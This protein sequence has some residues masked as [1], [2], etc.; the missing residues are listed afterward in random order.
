MTKVLK[1][2]RILTTALSVHYKHKTFKLSEFSFC[3]PKLNL[4]G[5]AF[6]D[7][8]MDYSGHAARH[9]FWWRQGMFVGSVSLCG[10]STIAEGAGN[11]SAD[12]AS[13][14]KV[15]NAGAG[16]SRLNPVAKRKAEEEQRRLGRLGRPLAGK[17]K[18]LGSLQSILRKARATLSKT[19]RAPRTLSPMMS[20]GINPRKSRYVAHVLQLPHA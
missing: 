6:R 7:D 8:T 19:L 3:D 10:D 16:P 14:R 4:F 11:E 5:S 17:Q 15:A 12:M 1:M 20:P 18:R 2:P 9:A 13:T